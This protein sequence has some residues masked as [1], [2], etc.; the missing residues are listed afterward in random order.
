M[1]QP[2]FG[3]ACLMIITLAARTTFTQQILKPSLWLTPTD[4]PRAE[5]RQISVPVSLSDLAA[6]SQRRVQP[7]NSSGLRRRFV[8]GTSELRARQQERGERVAP[9]LTQNTIPYWSDSFTYQG[10][11]FTYKMV[12]TDPQTGSGTT[13]IPTELIPFR[14]VF[15]D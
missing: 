9:N 15:P 8:D 1:R 14:F 11:D 2:H 12:G 13:L 6:R 3:I 10:L 5:Q 7:L 4:R